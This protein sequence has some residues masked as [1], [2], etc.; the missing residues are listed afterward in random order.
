MNRPNLIKHF[1]TVTAVAQKAGVTFQH[2]S[3]KIGFRVSQNLAQ[4]IS[5][6]SDMKF[7]EKQYEPR[8]VKRD[9][10]VYLSQTDVNTVSNLKRA[11]KQRHGLFFDFYGHMVPVES[12]MAE[13]ETALIHAFK[14][15]ELFKKED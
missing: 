9:G 11:L 5:E 4:K 6:N 7:D 8:K 2:F 3:E 15:H 14:N 10:K 13:G 12:V 1:G